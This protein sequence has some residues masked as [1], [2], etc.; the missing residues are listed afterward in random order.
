MPATLLWP[1]LELRPD[2][3]QSWEKRKA[4]CGSQARLWG[5]RYGC[6]G[7][8]IR[9]PPCQAHSKPWQ[10]WIAAGLERIIGCY[11]DENPSGLRFGIGRRLTVRW[12]ITSSGFIAR[13]TVN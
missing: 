2:Q 4:G 5:T 10:G 12:A 13:Q 7:P 3:I 11:E 1:V 9:D 8:G 6:V